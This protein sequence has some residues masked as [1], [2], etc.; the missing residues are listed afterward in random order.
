MTHHEHP[1]PN[2]RITWASNDC[3]IGVCHIDASDPILCPDCMIWAD[4]EIIC[5]DDIEDQRKDTPY[6]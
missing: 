5:A 6:D 4:M 3:E 1:C 2:C